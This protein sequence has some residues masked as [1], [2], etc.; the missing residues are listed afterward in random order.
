MVPIREIRPENILGVIYLDTGT[1]GQVNTVK[2][3]TMDGHIHAYHGEDLPLALELAKQRFRPEADSTRM[4]D[5][6][7]PE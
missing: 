2:L 7:L 4:S 1:P 5:R 6:P 3:I